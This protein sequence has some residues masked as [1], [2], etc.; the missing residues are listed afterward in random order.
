MV[1]GL[2]VSGFGVW[3]SWFPGF[4]ASRV[5]KG[6]EKVQVFATSGVEGLGA[7]IPKP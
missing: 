3:G 1:W 5:C 4:R 2:G 7:L 6:R